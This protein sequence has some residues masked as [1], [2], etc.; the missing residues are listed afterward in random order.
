M[1]K[2][3]SGQEGGAL[4][5]YSAYEGYRG[6]EGERDADIDGRWGVWIELN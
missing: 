6:S 2:A 4:P 5:T 3:D 1:T